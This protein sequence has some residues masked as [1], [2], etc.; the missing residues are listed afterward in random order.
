M[1]YLYCGNE[2]RPAKDEVEKPS[3]E[4]KFLDENDQEITSANKDALNDAQNRIKLQK[5]YITLCIF[6]FERTI[7]C[8]HLTENVSTMR[9]V[10]R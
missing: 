3:I 10:A 4:I 7:L 2:H 5:M 6:S 1:L 9:F 8:A